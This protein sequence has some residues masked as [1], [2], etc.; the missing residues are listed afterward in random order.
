MAIIIVAAPFI[1][2]FL[3]HYELFFE[4]RIMLTIHMI[5][6]E[7]MLATI[8]FTRLS[9]MF[10]FWLIRTHIGSEFGAVRHSRDY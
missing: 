3:A 2:G 8:P 7:I 4:Y 10:F 5:T 1:T 6:G 9:H